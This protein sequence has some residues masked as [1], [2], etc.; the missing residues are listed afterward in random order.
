M[1][2]R[3]LSALQAAKLR[4]LLGAV[5]ESN[6][7][8][9]QKL[10]DAGFDRG[11]LESEAP[12]ERLLPALPFTRKAELERD[13]AEHPPYGTNLTFPLSSYNRL[14][15][16]SGTSGGAPLRWLD[17][18]ESWSWFLGCWEQVY[19][20][21]RVEAR[22]RLFFPFSFGPFLGFWGAFEAAFRRGSFCLAGGGMT[23]EA[24][25]RA[26]LEHR[27][28]VIACTPTYALRLAEAAAAEGIDI[29]G[30]AV[31]ALLVAGEPG[32]S[33]EATRRRI[34]SAWGARSYDHSG[35][36]EIGAYAFECHEAPG[37]LHLIEEEFIGEVLEPSSENPAAGGKTGELVLTNLGRT[38]S[39][40]LRYRT[41]DL[42]R[43]GDG[44]CACGRAGLRFEGGIL[45]RLDDMLFIRGNNV[46]P[47]AV[48]A[49]IRRFPEV[50][51]YRVRVLQ[52]GPMSDLQVEIEPFPPAPAGVAGSVEGAG[53]GDADLARRVARALQDAL[54]FRVEVQTVAPGALPR[55]DMKACRFL[56]PG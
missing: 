39:P 24:R 46:Y 11:L 33:I 52:S 32:G 51:E 36:T 53:Q 5:L 41:G 15:Q 26:I 30:S 7:F 37:G 54:L 23:T 34:E 17:T 29:R 3:S 27:I 22:D 9:R 50:A 4:A 35:M 45:G 47:S 20:A 44:P 43:A 40:L 10:E 16:T 38:G 2:R 18:A 6:A 25:L 1:E 8:Y 13:Q 14:H 21:A 55:F 28:T 31:R 42:V 49:V 12:L 56:R 19:A 48:E